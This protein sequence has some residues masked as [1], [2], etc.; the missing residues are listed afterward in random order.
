LALNDEGGGDELVHKK[1]P[2]RFLTIVSL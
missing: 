1:T 2:K